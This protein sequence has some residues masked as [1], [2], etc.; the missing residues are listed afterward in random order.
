MTPSLPKNVKGLERMLRVRESACLGLAGSGSSGSRVV[1]G[2]E[3][4]AVGTVSESQRGAVWLPRASGCDNTFENVV[5]ESGGRENDAVITVSALQRGA[6]WS[7]RA[8]G[9]AN[10]DE[11]A[12]LETFGREDEAV[13]TVSESSPFV[14]S[15]AAAVAATVG[16]ETVDQ[17][18]VLHGTSSLFLNSRI[19]PHGH[20]SRIHGSSP[21]SH[22][23]ARLLLLL[24]LLVLLLGLPPLLLP[25]LHGFH[26]RLLL[27][28]LM[29]QVH[30]PHLC[31][32]VH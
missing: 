31:M 18:G 30:V 22:V 28:L 23:H 20:R 25:L 26:V 15:G 9:A 14:K 10:S 8:S 11:D 13:F 16:S 24:C 1:A 12:V 19:H 29:L 5:L 27:L 6:L 7:P 17:V 32:I 21:F 4:H 3:S 2:C